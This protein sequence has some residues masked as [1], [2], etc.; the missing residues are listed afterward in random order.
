MNSSSNSPLIHQV[1]IG[2]ADNFI[3]F[4]GDPETK[5]MAVVDPAWDVP[6]IRQIVADLG[7]QISAIWL[8]HGHSDHTN[9]VAELLESNPVPVYISSLEASSLRPD[10]PGLIDVNDGDTLQVG[11]IHFDVIHTPGHSPGGQCFLHGNQLI[12]GDTIFIDG[13]GRCD[14]PISDVKAMF[15]SIHN[16]VMTLADDTVIYPGHNYGP[17][18]TDTLANQKKTNLFR[19]ATNG[20]SFIKERMG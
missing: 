19:V 4:I 8:T 2:P 6:Q 7:Y 11:E 5:Q 12:A 1:G 10:V 9:G 17:M 20:E 18:P 3:Y 15:N 13:C 16:R 14:S